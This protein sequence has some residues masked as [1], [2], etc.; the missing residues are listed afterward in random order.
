MNS[1]LEV[2]LNRAIPFEGDK[3]RLLDQV[4]QALSGNNPQD[5]CEFKT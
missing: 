1:T 2:L 4:T 5:V 3:I